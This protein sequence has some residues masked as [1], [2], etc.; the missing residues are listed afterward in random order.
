MDIVLGAGV[1][2]TAIALS[3][4]LRGRE[5]ILIDRQAP[6]L[7][8][9]F[10]NAGLIEQSDLVP[11]A[12]P[13]DPLE[14]AGYATGRDPRAGFDPF[15]LP[16]LAPFLFSY[17]RNSAPGRLR[18]VTGM[19][20]PLFLNS[21]AAHKEL[22]TAAGALDL[23]RPNGWLHLYRDGPVGKDMREAVA[24]S[25]DHGQRVDILDSGEIAA[26]MPQL[27]RHIASAVH[28]RDSASISDP[29]ELTRL[30][31]EHFAALGGTI[32][33]AAISGATQTNGGWTV[34]TDQGP[35]PGETL[36]VALGPW[37]TDLTRKLDYRIPFAV[38]RGYHMHFAIND[39]DR[40]TLPAID[41]QAGI[42]LTPMARGLR[43]TTAIEFAARDA[44]PNYRQIDLGERAT[45]QLFAI[46]A[47]LD[48]SPWL[49]SRPVTP[50]MRPVIGPAPRHKRLW[51]AFGHAH[52][53]LTLAAITGRLLA[54]AIETGSPSAELMPFAPAR[55]G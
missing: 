41:A 5:V 14:L 43:M 7:A 52:H 24:I 51:F 46:G 23:L 35:I 12:F 21:I 36:I 19:L 38:K 18:G 17:W 33:T 37:S 10:G 4:R 42:A 47:R 20:A 11:R 15:F 1:V 30:Y 55:F 13:R 40:P 9:S 34:A 45:R 49:G 29:G 22:M 53:G 28:W 50:D 27:K 39:S 2:G 25:R 54:E 6:G 26:R 32:M 3:L 44:R 48:D 16:R 8:T 31:A